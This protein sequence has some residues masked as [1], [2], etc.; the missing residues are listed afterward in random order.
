MSFF[1]YYNDIQLKCASVTIDDDQ[2]QSAH[3][4]NCVLSLYSGRLLMSLTTSITPSDIEIEKV[5]LVSDTDPQ[6]LKLRT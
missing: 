1:Y 2:V 5:N 3:R 4:L 6:K